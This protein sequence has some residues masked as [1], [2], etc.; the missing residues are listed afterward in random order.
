MPMKFSFTLDD[1]D[2]KYF[3]RLLREAKAL[4]RTQDESTIIPAVRDLVTRVRGMKRLPSFASEA[5][6]TLETLTEML[7]DQDYAL[8]KPIAT[9]ALSALAYFAH[10]EDLI[11]DHIPGLGFLDDAI[12][13]KIVEEEFTYDIAGYREF[14]RFR[15]GAELRPWTNVARERLPRRLA[16]KRKQIRAKIDKKKGARAERE[17]R[18]AR[19]GNVGK[20]RLW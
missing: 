6:D 10:A 15:G 9:R 14:K 18:A 13:V 8:P 20:G 11:P 12:M 19:G 7:E 17:E 5:I 2:I 16:E 3:K 1:G 4:A